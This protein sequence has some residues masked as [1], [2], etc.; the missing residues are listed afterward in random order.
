MRAWQIISTR[1]KFFLILRSR[2]SACCKLRDS[3]IWSISSVTWA[4]HNLEIHE[5]LNSKQRCN[6][7]SNWNCDVKIIT[8]HKEE[9]K[10]K[11]KRSVESEAALF[12][13]SMITNC[14]NF[15]L[16]CP[17]QL[18]AQHFLIRGKLLN[19]LLSDAIFFVFAGAESNLVAFLSKLRKKISIHVKIFYR[20]Y[21]ATFLFPR[22]S[23]CTMSFLDWNHTAKFYRSV[24]TGN[25]VAWC[26]TPIQDTNK[27]ARCS[28]PCEEGEI[29]FN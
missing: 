21:F 8:S 26:D 13:Y 4:Q 27:N 6:H 12:N 5:N 23:D 7:C 11:S 14:V 1:K 25:N 15:A 29:R 22:Y 24:M 28:E 18:V 9:M 20:K 17:F 19:L 2:I 10:E 16:R 3:A